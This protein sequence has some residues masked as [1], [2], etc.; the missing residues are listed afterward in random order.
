M[1]VVCGVADSSRDHSHLGLVRVPRRRRTAT[2]EG[3]LLEQSGRP[4]RRRRR[5]AR[6][7]VRSGASQFA[8][9]IPDRTAH[10]SIP[11]DTARR[12]RRHGAPGGS[13]KLRGTRIAP[14]ALPSPPRCR[15]CVR[16]VLGGNR[17]ECLFR[18]RP[19]GNCAAASL[20]G[21]AKSCR[22]PD[23]WDVRALRATAALLLLG[24]AVF[25]A[26]LTLVGADSWSGIPRH[27]RLYVAISCIGLLAAA[28]FSVR[29]WAAAARSRRLL[30]NGR[31]SS[32]I[33]R[34]SLDP[35]RRCIGRWT[36]GRTWRR[37]AVPS[38]W[39]PPEDR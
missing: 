14:C 33:A 28:V 19:A 16:A 37:S 20:G 1:G 32:P 35:P 25:A 8:R 5:A 7:A 15:R 13:A 10:V 31:C 6:I 12:L 27:V 26:A 23:H 2:L 38:S 30:L 9:Q 22:V 4:L 24:V 17:A 21:R 39:R 29:A 11:V 3:I 36:A 34:C 18:A